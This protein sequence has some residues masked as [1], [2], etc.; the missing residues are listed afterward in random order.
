MNNANTA[1]NAR[2]E[3]DDLND[4]MEAA[5][6]YVALEVRDGALILSGEVDSEEMHEAAL[7]LAQPYSDRY[8]LAIE[9]AIEVLAMEPDTAS[10]RFDTARGGEVFPGEAET[11]TDVGTIDPGQSMDEAIP[12]F[13]PTDPVVGGQ[14]HRQDEIEVIG[15]FQTT[16][17][18]GDEDIALNQPFRG[19][20]Q[21]TEDVLRELREDA[22][23]T[24]LRVRVHTRDGVVFL[25]GEVPTLEDAENAEAVAGRVTGVVEVREE[26]KVTSMR[27][28]RAR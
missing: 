21:I 14:R 15:G 24:D 1:E 26:L 7:D 28:D 11:I 16:S 23:T 9:D 8:E 2:A 3:L 6:I 22:T 19:D 12:Y 18:L 17:M 5:G 25:V 20:E 4:T 13:P 27:A 10:Q